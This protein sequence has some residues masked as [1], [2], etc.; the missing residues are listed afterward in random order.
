MCMFQMRHLDSRSKVFLTK[1]SVATAT[2][3][4]P[5]SFGIVLKAQIT[6]SMSNYL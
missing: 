2:V 6:L 5:N 3:C 4:S 1:H